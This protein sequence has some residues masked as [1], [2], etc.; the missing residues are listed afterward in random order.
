M[1]FSTISHET[2]GYVD[3]VNSIAFAFFIII[4]IIDVGGEAKVYF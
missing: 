2:A 1:F 4:K 3:Q